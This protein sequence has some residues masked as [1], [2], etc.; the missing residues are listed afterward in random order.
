MKDACRWLSSPRLA[1]RVLLAWVGSSVAFHSEKWITTVAS[2]DHLSEQAAELLFDA[3]DYGIENA[4]IR[5]EGFVPFA[6]LQHRDGTRQAVRFVAGD[7]DEI[8]LAV[9]LASGRQRLSVVDQEIVAVAFVWDGYLTG[10]EQR[11]EAVLVEG[12]ELG[13]P[14]GVLLAQPYVRAE[15]NVQLQGDPVFC[16]SPEPLVRARRTAGSSR[17][18]EHDGQL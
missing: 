2:F 13:Q 3:L 4:G 9:S 16:G 6:F 18:G 15:H 17:D 8:D 12:Y 1:A 11:S 14:A 5:T 10:D 7:T